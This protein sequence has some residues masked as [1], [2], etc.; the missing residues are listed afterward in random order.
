MANENVLQNE[1]IKDFDFEAM[2]DLISQ[3]LEDQ[4][5]DLEVIKEQRDKIGTPESLVYAVIDAAVEGFNNN[6][7]QQFGADFIRDNGGLN[8]DLS[9]DA[10]FKPWTILLMENLQSTIHML[11]NISKS[12]KPCKATL[13]KRLKGTSDIIQTALGKLKKVLLK[14]LV[15]PMIKIDQVGQQSVGQI[16]IILCQQES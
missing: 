1:A 5:A 6:I 14:G 10:H 15:H 7:A 9:R 12:M 11:G 2:E 4:I 16:W 3:Q 13:K 8:L